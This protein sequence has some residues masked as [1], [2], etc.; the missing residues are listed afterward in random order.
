[1]LKLQALKRRLGHLQKRKNEKEGV[2]P[3]ATSA[4]GRS[5]SQVNNLSLSVWKANATR[6]KEKRIEAEQTLRRLRAAVIS[7]AKTIH[8]MKTLIQRPIP[9][10]SQL[11]SGG[12]DDDGAELLKTFADEL[13]ALYAQTNKV[14]QEADFKKATTLQYKPER[15]TMQNVEIF[16]NAEVSVLPFGFQETSRAILFLMMADTNNVAADESR[17]TSMVKYQLKCQV[18]SGKTSKLQVYSAMRKYVQPCRVAL[19]SR[20][21]IEGQAEIWGYHIHETGW[22]TMRLADPMLA[23]GTSGTDQFVNLGAKT[24]EEE[25]KEMGCILEGNFTWGTST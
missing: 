5:M 11:C 4:D 23:D 10:N 6:Q 19:V 15:K 22:I 16:D 24:A 3:T 2:K 14:M 18:E 9:E 21:I 20:A 1:M 25:V 17:D 8:Q 13:D 7:Q 12:E